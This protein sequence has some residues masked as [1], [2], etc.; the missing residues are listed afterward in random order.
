[1]IANQLALIRREMWEHR[2]LYVVPAVLGIVLVLVAITGQASVSAFGTHIDMALLGATNLSANER[3]AAISALLAGFAI[4]FVI[5][6]LILS[7]FYSLDSLYAERKDKSILFWRSMPVTDAETVISK[8]ITVISIIPLV[9][10]AIIAATQLAIL[11]VTSI[12]IGLR[13][14]NAW[15]LIWSAV[16]LLDNW[17]ATLIFIL[18]LSL[19]L[20]PF[21]GWFLL[22]SA[23][24]KRSPLLMALL[25]ILLLPMLE[26][27]I[28]GSRLLFDAIFAR[29]AHIPIYRNL[30][31]DSLFNK[32][33]LTEAAHDGIS[34]VSM[35]DVGRFLASPGLW[36]GLVVCGL[37]V[38]AAIYV[39]R[40]RGDS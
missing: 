30:D 23:Y 32:R 13:G 35:L 12:W 2:S 4:S 5:A 7:M 40:F 22:V 33:S 36:V 19:W 37:F 28:L 15:H 39:R 17:A 27:S 24:T 10:I 29:S 26:R 3:G 34:M 38:T 8:L 16:P 9:T 31:F 11:V 14:A 18:S 6:M 20:S 21:I 1:M 25:P